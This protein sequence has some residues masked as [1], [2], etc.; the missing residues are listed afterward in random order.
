MKVDWLVA[1]TTLRGL[2]SEQQEIVEM[3]AM[4]R[5]LPE[6]AKALG[7]H[8]SMIWRKVEKIKKLMDK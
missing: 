2:T 4:N 3:L 7:Q 8:R 1:R 6:I 5:T